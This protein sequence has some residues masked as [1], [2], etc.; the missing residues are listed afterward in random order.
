MQKTSAQVVTKLLLGVFLLAF[1]TMWTYFPT[2]KNLFVWDSRYY[3]FLHEFWISKLNPYHIIWML[4]SLEVSN[5]HPLTW[6]SWA[7]DYQIYGGLVPWGFHLSSNILHTI[8]SILVFAL[9]LV[10]FGLNSTG[11]RAYPFRTDNNALIAAFVGALL[12][13]IHPQHVESVAWVAERK[14]LLCQLF[15]LLS[16]LTYVK[17]TTCHEDIKSRWFYATLGLFVMALL[18]K[19]M[20]VTFPVILL[21]IDIYPLRRVDL[22]QAVNNSI[23]QQSLYTL[24]REKI[25]FFLLSLFLILITLHAQQGAMSNIDFYL[26]VLNAFNSIILYLTKFWLPTDLAPLYPYFVDVGE[27][28]TWKAFIP[29]LGVLGITLASLLAWTRARHM[30]LITWLFYL[31]TLSPVLGLIQVGHQ[32]AADRYTYLPMLPAYF[33]IAA[34]LLTVLNKIT[35]TK[36]LFVL[37]AI[38]PLIFLLSNKTRQQIQ[39]WESDQT[40]WNSTIML[41]PDNALAYMTFGG[42]YY[43]FYDYEKAAYYFEEAGKLKPN[44][45]TASAW[46]ALTD[47]HLGRYEKAIIYHINLGAASESMPELQADQFC[48]Q[49]NIGFI[50][51]K[52]DMLVESSDLF[53][54]VDPNSVLG[55]DAGIWLNWLEKAKQT[56]YTTLSNEDLPGI[57]TTLLPSMRNTLLP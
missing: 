12:F 44:N 37:L 4:L 51:A 1:I 2:T 42:Y 35:S 47:I 32:G 54:R 39:M 57:C 49:Y 55:Q 40:L 41:Y 21:L 34:G 48:I 23:T 13:A 27:S 15:L 5:W 19:P 8:N 18:S 9:T 10:V 26:R 52:M 36:R 20:A 56:E 14:D 17:Y 3:L 11:S 7:I 45:I 33:L 28:I 50:Y 22:M 24:L 43:N 38:L 31:V 29:F 25:P 30:W 53:S 6:L 46:L 16:M